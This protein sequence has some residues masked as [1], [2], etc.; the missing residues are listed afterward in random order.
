ML[1]KVR[2]DFRERCS[3]DARERRGARKENWVERASDHR[4]VLQ[5]IQP[6]WW[7]VLKSNTLLEES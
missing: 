3:S 5:K 7:K 6:G 1:E 4:A 2:R